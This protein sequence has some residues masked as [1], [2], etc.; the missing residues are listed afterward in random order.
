MQEK[1]FLTVAEAAEILGLKKSKT[2][3]MMRSG[4]LPRV[5]IGGSIRVPL[6]KLKVWCQQKSDESTAME[7]QHAPAQHR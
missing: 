1:A 4:L 5:R 2:Y 3:Q 7:G 6:D